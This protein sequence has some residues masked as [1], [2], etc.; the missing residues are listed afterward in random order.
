MFDASE[1][2]KYTATRC[3]ST[4]RIGLLLLLNYLL[5]KLSI[6]RLLTPD[7]C[8]LILFDHLPRPAL[9]VRNHFSYD[10]PS[11]RE[12]T[13]YKHACWCRRRLKKRRATTTQRRRNDDA[14]TT[15]H[16][17]NYNPAWSTICLR[18]KN[19]EQSLELHTC[20]TVKYTSLPKR[21]QKLNCR[22]TADVASSQ[23]L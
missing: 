18:W 19:V 5:L 21:N 20:F 9:L 17:R 22:T 16:T 3:F 11:L 6:T 13:S 8:R 7:T 10:S 12:N 14:A 2:C 1:S 23:L 4:T 15:K